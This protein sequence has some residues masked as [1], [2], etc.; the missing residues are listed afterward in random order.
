MFCSTHRQGCNVSKGPYF[1]LILYSN[2]NQSC[3]PGSVVGIATSY[4]LDGPGI[5]P[6]WRRDFAHLSRQALGPTQPCVQWIP[7]LSQ[8]K[9][10]RGV[11][12]SPH[13]LLVPW[14]WK[15]KL[16][17]TL[18]QALGLCTGRTAHRGSRGIDLPFL[19][20]GTRRGCGVSI[21]S[22]PLFIPGKDPV[23]IVQEAG[24]AP[25]PVWTAAKNLVPIGIRSPDRPA[26]C[27]S[28]YRLR[29]PA[30]MVM[31]E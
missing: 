17:C 3:G 2:L 14:S 23:H 8:G 31:K 15:S 21:T 30:H 18:V 9:S 19:D 11:T 10:G 12:L 22:R 13:P 26:R 28:L 5:E 7:V 24:W 29:Y 16:K 27:Q 1:K 20:H 4:G 25:R 6:W